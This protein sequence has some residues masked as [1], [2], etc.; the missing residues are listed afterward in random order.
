[1]V[2]ISPSKKAEA[3]GEKM[4][5]SELEEFKCKIDLMA[6][7]E[8]QGYVKDHRASW[9]DHHVMRHPG[10]DDK[11]VVKFGVKRARHHWGYYSFRDTQDHG[12]IVDFVKNRQ[13]LS[14][15]AIFKE[16][17]PWIGKS[18][19]E[20]S[21]ALTA[22]KP[23]KDRRDVETAY[24]KMC[25]ALRHPYLENERGIPSR[26]L[27]NPRFAGRIKVDAR[28]NAVFPHFDRQGLCGFESKNRGWT[29]FSAGGT[30][31][32]WSSH[33]RPD[34]KH[35]V[36][37]EAG[38]DSLSYA[39][40]FPDVQTRYKSIGGQ[41]N[42][43]QPELMRSAAAAMPRN[44]TIVAAMDAD[45]QGAKLA[46]IVRKAVELTG[47]DD[48]AYVFEEPFGYKDWNDQLRG[49][50]KASVPFRMAE[51]SVA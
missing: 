4:S 19:V 37:C 14:W 41:L 43:L 18:P 47:R 36:F 34:D 7:A 27:E 40:L 23:R 1:M 30:K 33:E 22:V 12:S 26:L 5:E 10:T 2:R 6:Y 46:E 48:L 25:D 8:A 32:L 16:L 28:G 20:V 38:I 45:P 15:G 3:V 44:S 42:P 31:G 17:R 39:V 51:P 50:R 35:L 49:T 9:V 13:R 21:T 29:S 24:A 11:I